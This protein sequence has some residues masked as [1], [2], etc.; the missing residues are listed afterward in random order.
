M[1]K[2]EFFTKIK[3]GLIVSCYANTDYNFQ[4]SRPQPM[5]ALARSV[6]DGGA[7]CIRVNLVH[8]ALLKKV[9]NIPIYGI[10]KVYR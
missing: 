5:L 1:D 10:E 4:F 9:L 2:L 3:Q 8:V 7:I 6:V